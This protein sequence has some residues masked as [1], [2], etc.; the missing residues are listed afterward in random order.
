MKLV[1]DDEVIIGSANQKS[2]EFTIKASAKAFKILSSNLYKNKIRAIV[3]ELACNCVDAHILNNNQHTPFDVTAPTRLDPRFIIRDYGPGLND[4]AMVHMYTTFFESTKND[5]NEFIGALGLG[6]KSPLA[7]TNTFTVVSYHDGIASGYTIMMDQGQPCIR[8]IFREKMKEDEHTGLEI[9]VPV[10]TTDI[11]SWSREILY[12]LRPF[13]EVPPNI[14]RLNREVNYFPTTNKQWFSGRNFDYES[15]GLYA[16]YGKI[17][18]PIT[19]VD[20]IS[21][22]WLKSRYGTVYIHFPLGE[23]DITPSREELSLDEDT[24]A[25]IQKRVNSLEEETIAE[26]IKSFEEIENPRELSRKINSLG[27]DERSVLHNRNIVIKGQNYSYWVSKYNIDILSKTVANSELSV[28]EC[29]NEPRR[30]RFTDGWHSYRSSTKINLNKIAGV[31][32]THL[33]VLIDDKPSKRIATVRALWAEAEIPAGSFIVVSKS[34]DEESLELVEK[35]KKVMEGDTIKMYRTS[36][37]EP[38]RKKLP[39]YGVKST[40]K[41]PKSPNIQLHYIKDSYWCCD[42]LTLTSSEILELEGYA[43]GRNRDTPYVFPEKDEWHN[44]SIDSIRELAKE[45]GIKRFYAIRP[46]AYNAALKNGD[47]ESLTDKIISDLVN[48]IDEVDYDDYVPT[49][50]SNNRVVSNVAKHTDLN[51]ILGKFTESGNPNKYTAKLNS[52]S[53]ILAHTRYENGDDLALCLKIYNKLS[54]EAELVFSKKVQDF[55]AKYPVI[56]QVLNNWNIDSETVKDIVKIVKAVDAAE[57]K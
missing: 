16:V 54:K 33:Y 34:D 53:R 50:F 36:E 29:C 14:K 6:S 24:I 47:F 13:G 42:N 56:N 26:D 27:S 55:K 1:T 30:K 19:G 4:N 9:T 44:I 40:E 15:S 23:L 41:R 7:Y 51:F 20:G 43:I 25:N 3:R 17:V 45:C 38:Q 46:S 37:L 21:S 10:K 2:T 5:S 49:S 18:Y 22:K 57:E 11:D 28:Y 32:N 31:D 8:P 12:V 35:I 52:M 48:A 39:D